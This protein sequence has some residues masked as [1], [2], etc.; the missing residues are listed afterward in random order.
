MQRTDTYDFPKYAEAFGVKNS[1]VATYSSWYKEIVSSGLT[2]DLV[3]QAGAKFYNGASSPDDG[4]AIFNTSVAYPVVTS[5][6][7]ALKN[8]A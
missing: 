4:F 2:G 5:A 6:A 1:Q 3:W 7:V 8:R